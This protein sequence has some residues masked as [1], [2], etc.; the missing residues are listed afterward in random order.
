MV[1]GILVWNE[2][3]GVEKVNFYKDLCFEIIYK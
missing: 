3:I 1:I 2:R